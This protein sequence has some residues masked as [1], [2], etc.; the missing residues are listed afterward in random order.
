M[1]KKDLKSLLLRMNFTSTQKS[2]R[3]F[4]SMFYMFETKI[5]LEVESI[6]EKAD[7]FSHVKL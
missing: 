7:R 3:Y 4:I 6:N 1:T 2:E 5:T